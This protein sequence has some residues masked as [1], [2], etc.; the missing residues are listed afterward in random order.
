MSMS[1]EQK[2]EYFAIYG[3]IIKQVVKGSLY[4]ECVQTRTVFEYVGHKL[5]L[6]KESAEQAL[7]QFIENSNHDDKVYDVYV[8]PCDEGFNERADAVP[9]VSTSSEESDDLI[10]ITTIKTNCKELGIPIPATAKDLLDYHC[11]LLNDY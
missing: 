9:E 10:P 11:Y 4:G 8:V 2:Q 7:K 3:F 1:K 6:T 5:Y